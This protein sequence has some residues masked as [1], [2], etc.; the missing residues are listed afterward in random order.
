MV[1]GKTKRS[2]PLWIPIK[3]KGNAYEYD[4]F[5]NEIASLGDTF[6]IIAL[7]FK[8]EQKEKENGKIIADKAPALFL[9][10]FKRKVQLLGGT[11]IKNNI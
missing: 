9:T 11:V 3:I 10:I 7:S 1:W 6:E 2:I 5:Q 8:E 4:A